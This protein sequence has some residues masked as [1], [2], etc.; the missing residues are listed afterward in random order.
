MF[1]YINFILCIEDMSKASKEILTIARQKI[2][3]TVLEV[4]K[5]GSY[6]LQLIFFL[7]TQSNQ[8]NWCY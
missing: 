1:N 6:L 2:T 4:M 5:C 8:D 7:K 3:L